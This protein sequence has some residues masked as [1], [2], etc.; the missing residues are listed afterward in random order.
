MRNVTLLGFFNIASKECSY[1]SV[2]CDPI[3][4]LLLMD[5][6]WYLDS[7]GNYP[8]HASTSKESPMTL[9]PHVMVVGLQDS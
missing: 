4:G 8:P 3:P 5:R 6:V 1:P 7:S 2:D 9:S